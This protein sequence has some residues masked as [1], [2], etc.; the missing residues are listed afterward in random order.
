MVYVWQCAMCPET[1]EVIRKVDDIDVPPEI[2]EHC[3]SSSFSG[4]V[5][6]RPS[7]CKGYILQGTGWHDDQYTKHRSRT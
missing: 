3:H 1:A 5:I 6:V 4:R 7:N 2:C